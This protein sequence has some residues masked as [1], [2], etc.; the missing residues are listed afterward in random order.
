M[1]KRGMNFNAVT[2]GVGRNDTDR[3]ARSAFFVEGATHAGANGAYGRFEAVQLETALFETGLPVE[4]PAA[5]LKDPIF[6]LTLGATRRVVTAGGVE[7]AVGAD[8]T[9]DRTPEALRT[10]YGAHPV[11]FHLFFSLRPR[12]GA[13]GRMWNMRMSQPM[14]EGGQ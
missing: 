10:L 8:V 2:I 6:A 13:M 9:V 11:S 5:L 1:R 12:A 14:R 3:G 4:G 7:G